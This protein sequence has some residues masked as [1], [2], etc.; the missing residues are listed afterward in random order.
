MC[1]WAK[2]AFDVRIRWILD[3]RLSNKSLRCAEHRATEISFG[4]DYKGKDPV[5]FDPFENV[6]SGRPLVRIS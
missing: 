5:R 4:F 3:V 6:H 2:R 1:R